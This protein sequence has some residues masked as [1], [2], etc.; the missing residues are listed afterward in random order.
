MPQVIN[1][2]WART[3]TYRILAIDD[4][5]FSTELTRLA[6]EET[7]LYLVCEINDPE[8]AVAGAREFAP[9][10]VVM[11]VDMPGLDGRA[12]ALLIQC[13]VGLKDVPILFVTSRIAE[14]ENGGGNAFGWFGPLAKP[15]S[16]KRLARVVESILQHGT[17]ESPINR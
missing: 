8:T 4:D 1:Q 5:P 6:L 7:G 11:D 12:A 10:L 2:Q 16:P 9:D 15:V 17:L 13:E 3:H 14:G